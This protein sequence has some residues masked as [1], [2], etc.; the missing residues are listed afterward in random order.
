MLQSWH[1]VTT[2]YTKMQSA[3]HDYLEDTL[4]MY[5]NLRDLCGFLPLNGVDSRNTHHQERNTR[6]S[7][8]GL[9]VSCAS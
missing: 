6:V 9:G 4:P 7:L 2:H 3:V 5:P 1:R 8:I